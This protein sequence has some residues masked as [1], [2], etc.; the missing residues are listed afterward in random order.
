MA[1]R[2]YEIFLVIEATDAKAHELA[3]EA[4][5]GANGTRALE[6]GHVVTSTARER[7]TDGSVRYP[8]W[9]DWQEEG[10]VSVAVTYD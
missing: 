8:D 10:E 1:K 9:D 3:N 6:D 4:W 5:Y 7:L 2:R